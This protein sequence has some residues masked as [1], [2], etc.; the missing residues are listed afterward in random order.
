MYTIHTYFGDV[1]RFLAD[2]DEC[3][4]FRKMLNV[5]VGGDNG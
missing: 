3:T 1:V 5:V 2:D 4:A